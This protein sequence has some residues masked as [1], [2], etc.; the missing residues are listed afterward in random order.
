M[1]FVL[2]LLLT[3]FAWMGLRGDVGV[4]TFAT[5]MLLGAVVWRVERVR[6]SKPFQPGRALRLVLRSVA[7]LSS[8]GWE[9]LVANWHQLRIVLAPRIDVQPC[10]AHFDTQLESQ[11]LRLVL[12]V[13]ISLTPGTLICDEV[14]RSDGSV[15]LWIHIL[16]SDDPDA[17]IERIRQRLE[18][19]LC[20][21]EAG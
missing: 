21:L 17:V 1:A 3:G 14:E 13:M 20:A 19:P 12:G 2:F 11:A 7:V 8:F 6:S 10:W 5:G 15:C 9:L 4:G 18:A 16:D